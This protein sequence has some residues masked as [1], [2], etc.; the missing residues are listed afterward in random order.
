ML[1]YEAYIVFDHFPFIFTND[2]YTSARVN[3]ENTD[4]TAFWG[5]EATSSIISYAAL[6]S[7]WWVMGNIPNHVSFIFFNYYM[8]V[9]TSE[10]FQYGRKRWYLIVAV[11]YDISL[12]SASA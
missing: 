12:H 10:T 3:F 2:V 5:M 7:P 8:R 1:L 11:A 6:G 4:V 9:A